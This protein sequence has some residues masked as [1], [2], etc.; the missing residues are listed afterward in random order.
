MGKLASDLFNRQD[1]LWVQIML[2]KYLSCMLSLD[3][4]SPHIASKIWQHIVSA[5]DQIKDG[6][7]WAHGF[8]CLIRDNKDKWI[9]GCSLGMQSSNVLLCELF[10]IWKGLILAWECGCKVVVYE[11][12]CLEAYLLINQRNNFVQEAY[13]DILMRIKE[14]LL[15]SWVAS[16]MLI[17]RT[18]NGAADLMAK[19]AARHQNRYMEWLEPW[20]SL[21]SVI[22][23]ELPAPS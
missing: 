8:G 6:F 11:T 15:R 7:S 16:V 13:R 1:K 23:E 21:S 17:Q 12:D 19:E 10:A 4:E 22:L 5:K 3:F 14:T 9:K 2:A 18:A 20:D